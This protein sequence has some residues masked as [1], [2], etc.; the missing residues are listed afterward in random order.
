MRERETQRE[1]KRE[2]ETKRKRKVRSGVT[3]VKREKM[4]GREWQVV[5]TYY[6]N[7]NTHAGAKISMLPA[8]QSEGSKATNKQGKLQGTNAMCVVGNLHIVCGP[9]VA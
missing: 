1:R 6:N 2:N 9:G 8:R 4:C 7:I 3:A 5:Y